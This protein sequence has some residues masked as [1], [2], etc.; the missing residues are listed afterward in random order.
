MQAAGSFRVVAVRA[1][2]QRLVLDEALEQSR[3]EEMRK[4]LLQAGAYR[5]ITVEP[6]VNDGTLKA[7]VNDGSETVAF[8]D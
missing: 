1:D 7:T 5:E 8:S 6:D 4:V 3:A 2:G